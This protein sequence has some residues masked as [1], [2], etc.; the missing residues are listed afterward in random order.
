MTTWGDVQT[1]AKNAFDVAYNKQGYPT[2][3]DSIK[4]AVLELLKLGF[5][6]EKPD[7]SQAKAREG[8]FRDLTGYL[9]TIN[10]QKATDSVDLAG[11]VFKNLAVPLVKLAIN[12]FGVSASD[13]KQGAARDAWNAAAK[14]VG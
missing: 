7:D 10:G 12:P 8:A 11:S 5:L 14:L 2:T 4:F 9:V 3:G 1:M 13:I 6:V